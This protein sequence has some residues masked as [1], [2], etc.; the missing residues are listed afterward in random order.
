MKVWRKGGRK[1]KTEKE[2]EENI[3]G[4]KIL[5]FA[6][7]KK[8]SEIFGEGNYFLQRRRKRRKIL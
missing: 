5:L 6:E 2:K 8:R 7:E 3:W 1:R 4:R